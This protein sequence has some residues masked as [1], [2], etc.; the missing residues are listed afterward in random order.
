MT[1]ANPA[2]LSALDAIADDSMGKHCSSIDQVR[3]RRCL[4]IVGKRL[5]RVCW[6]SASQAQKG[7]Y[8][9]AGLQQAGGDAATGIL[10]ISILA[11]DS[12][13]MD[14]EAGVERIRQQNCSRPAP[15]AMT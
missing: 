10:H 8:S 13:E 9:T 11:Y 14:M 5:A 2:W 1:K 7:R 3:S 6:E 12:T 15:A 4:H